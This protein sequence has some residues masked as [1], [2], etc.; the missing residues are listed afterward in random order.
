MLGLQSTVTLD[1]LRLTFTQVKGTF[2]YIVKNHIINYSYTDIKVGNRRQSER[3]EN[4]M[5]FPQD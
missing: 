2:E 1:M 4:K 5:C 3:I